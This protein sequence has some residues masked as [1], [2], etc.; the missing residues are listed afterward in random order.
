MDTARH[1]GAE[2]IPA[3]YLYDPR[4]GAAA[5]GCTGT[6]NF[7][8]ASVRAVKQVGSMGRAGSADQFTVAVSSGSATTASTSAAAVNINSNVTI[9]DSMASGSAYIASI[10]LPTV[11]TCVAFVWFLLLH[12]ISGKSP[13]TISV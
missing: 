13:L 8:G 4:A 10:R 5:A 7:S 11:L 12:G 1:G 3:Q 6:T 2:I 9:T